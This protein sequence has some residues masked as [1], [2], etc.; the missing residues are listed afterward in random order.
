MDN[1]FFE[2]KDNECYYFSY[3]NINPNLLS[4]L[5]NSS[6]ESILYQNCFLF[7]FAR[8]F[9]DNGDGTSVASIHQ[10]YDVKTYG[11][12]YKITFEQ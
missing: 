8:I 5:V 11:I 4:S 2:L 1:P 12:V 10:E 7:N 3:S 9:C 6:V